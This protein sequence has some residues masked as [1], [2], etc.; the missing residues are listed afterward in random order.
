LQRKFFDLWRWLGYFSTGFFIAARKR[1][2]FPPV[3]EAGPSRF[4]RIFAGKQMKSN[5]GMSDENAG[6]KRAD[7]FF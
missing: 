1:A 2:A 3:A 5:K 7:C 6:S 4:A